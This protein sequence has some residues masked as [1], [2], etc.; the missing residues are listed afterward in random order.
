MA[1]AGPI[2]VGG[3]APV[4]GLLSAEAALVVWSLPGAPEEPTTVEGSFGEPIARLASVRLPLVGGGV[5]VVVAMPRPAEDDVSMIVGTG[6]AGVRA[7]IRYARAEARAVDPAALFKGLTPAARLTL[8]SAILDGWSSLFRLKGSRSYAAFVQRLARVLAGEASVAP[9]VARAGGACLLEFAAKAPLLKVKSCHLARAGAVLPLKADVTVDRRSKDG[10]TL[11]RLVADLPEAGAGDDWL[12]LRG[13]KALVIRRVVR[14]ERDTALETWWRNRPDRDAAL[15]EWIVG[16]LDRRS[17]TARAAA[18]EFQ[19]RCP[20]EPRRV[21]GG[22]GLP[23]AQIELAVS[24]SVGILASGWWRDPGG[25]VSRLSLLDETDAPRPLDGAF[26]TYPGL[27]EGP[28]GQ[29]QPVTGFTAFVPGVRAPL[30]QPRFLLE[31]KS[32]ARHLLVPDP[33]PVDLGEARAMALRA[34]PPQAIDDAVLEGC[35]APVLG[36]LQRRLVE[37]LGAPTVRRIGTPVDRP[38][39]SLVIPLYKVLDFLKFQVAAFASDP[40]IAQKAEIVYV[41]DSPEQAEEVD[42]LLTGLHL[43]Y[44]LPITLVVMPRNAGYAPACNRGA[45][46]A[47]GA[48]LALLNSDVIPIEPGWLGVLAQRLGRGG[49]GAVGP[50]LLFEDDSVQHAGMYFA[51]DH[52]GRWHNHHYHKGMP[53][54]YAPADVERDVPAITGACVVTTKALYDRVGGFTEDYVIGDYEDSDLSLKMRAAG[55]SIRYVPAAELYHL[56]R[57]SIKA[58]SDYM[59]GVTSQYNSWLHARRWADTM[60]ALMTPSHPIA[61]EVAA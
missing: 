18:L 42:H 12:I 45:A 20:I 50:K 31:L 48:L 39:A 56:E 38:L 26:H 37:G 21:N 14:P 9:V 3:D 34:V 47:R 23:A 25:F 61:R 17:E 27:V 2:D 40:Q 58:S 16:A 15:R 28:A 33:Q 49:V 43:V 55:A 35:L 57:R 52:R 29:R 30:L 36:D 54:H 10:K 4:L 1:D 5:R 32:G 24:S 6:M 22:Q 60:Q 19:L 44:G 53:R 59:R 51:R 7:E 46:V 11:H 13:D 8:A 41:L